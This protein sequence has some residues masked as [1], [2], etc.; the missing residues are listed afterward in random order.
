[1]KLETIQIQGLW[2]KRRGDKVI[3]LIQREDGEWY[4]ATELKNGDTTSSCVSVSGL[5]MAGKVD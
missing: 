5:A 2:L 3:A 4:E 1:M